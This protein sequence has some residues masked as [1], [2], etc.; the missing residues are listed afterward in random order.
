M[1]FATRHI[2]LVQLDLKQDDENSQLQIDVSNRMP[3][4]VVTGHIF[5]NIYAPERIIVHPYGMK[6]HHNMQVKCIKVEC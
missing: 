6:L 3:Q 5:M 2:H 1:I 4:R